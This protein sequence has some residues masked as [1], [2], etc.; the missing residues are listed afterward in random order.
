MNEKN[1][2]RWLWGISEI[3]RKTVSERFGNLRLLGIGMGLLLLCVIGALLIRSTGSPEGVPSSPAG[4]TAVPAETGIAATPIVQPDGMQ[5]EYVV[6]TDPFM[7][8]TAT[9]EYQQ[10]GTAIPGQRSIDE[11]ERIYREMGEQMPP[12]VTLTG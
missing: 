4:V 7:D 9:F 8:Q 1:K 12:G 11:R 3:D 6:G 10:P 5:E 2:T